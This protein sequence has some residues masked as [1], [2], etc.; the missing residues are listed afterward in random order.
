MFS[1]TPFH[2][3]AKTFFSW[4]KRLRK[5]GDR[6]DNQAAI[7]NIPDHAHAELEDSLIYYEYTVQHKLRAGWARVN[8]LV[9]LLNVAES[10]ED[11]TK[12]KQ[13][14]AKTL[15]DVEK[16]MNDVSKQL[17]VARKNIK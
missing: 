9:F 5:N 11:E 13:M 2:A 4:L 8:G 3:I 16:T 10:K 7:G 12:I 1:N 15:F 14:L 17:S 6:N